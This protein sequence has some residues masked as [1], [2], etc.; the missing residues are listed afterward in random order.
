[1]VGLLTETPS[2]LRCALSQA[3]RQDTLHHLGWRRLRMA[4]VDRRQIL[5]ALQPLQ[6]KAA[7]VVRL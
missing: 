7:L 5:A 1:M 2:S 3:Q 4:L 6:L